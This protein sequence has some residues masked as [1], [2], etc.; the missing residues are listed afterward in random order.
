ML[1]DLTSFMAGFC[2]A[3]TVRV[4]GSV[5]AG[6]VGGSPLAVPVLVMPPRSTSAWV[7]V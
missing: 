5:T 7:V 6:P 3:G 1:A 2:S 4:D